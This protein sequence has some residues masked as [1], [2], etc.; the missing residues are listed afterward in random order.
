MVQVNPTVLVLA[1]GSIYQGWSL[2][3]LNT[4]IGEVVF[5]TGMTGYQEILTDP[6]YCGQIVIFTYPE[7]G[8]TGINSI[9]LESSQ[10]FVKGIVAKNLCKY[11]NNWR[12]EKSLLEYLHLHEIMYIYGLDTRSLAKH[13]RKVGS[14]NGAISNKLIDPKLL[15][16]KVKLTTPMQGADLVSKVTTRNIYSNHQQTNKQWYFQ[17]RIYNKIDISMRVVIIDFGVKTNILRRLQSL[18]CETIVV[19]ASTSVDKVLSYR[20]DGILLSNGPGDPAAVIYGIKTIK[21]LLSY[22]IPTFGICMGHQL[23]SLALGCNTY[24]LKFGHR[25]LNHPTGWFNKVHITSQNHGF[26]VSNQLSLSDQLLHA[27]HVNF[28]DTTI[29]G[30]SHMKLPVFSVQ[31]HPEASPGPHDSDYLFAYFISMMYYHHTNKL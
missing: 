21:E 9:D 25:G 10:P 12:S 17:Q 26:A 22:T 4:V 7:L 11:P 19:P 13:I 30:I 29:A 1:D 5:N 28:N 31:Y 2:G 20:P 27:M 18:N 16:Q 15:L 8:N 23:L 14:M 3:K 6:S 24:K